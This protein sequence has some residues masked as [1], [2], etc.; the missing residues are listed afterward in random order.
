MVAFSIF[1]SWNISPQRRSSSTMWLL[2]IMSWFSSILQRWL[3]SLALVSLWTHE[4]KH[5]WCV[6]LHAVTIFIM[7]KIISSGQKP[8]QVGFWDLLTW[9]QG[10]LHNFAIW[11]KLILHRPGIGQLSKE[12]QLL[13]IKKRSFRVHFWALGLLTATLFLSLQQAELETEFLILFHITTL[14]IY[15]LY[16]TLYTQQSQNNSINPSTNNTIIE[17]WIKILLGNVP[18]WMV[19]SYQLNENL[20]LKFNC[21]TIYAKYFKQFQSPKK[22]PVFSILF[23]P[24]PMGNHLC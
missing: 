21:F 10:E 9:L 15:L 18:L 3:M 23:F 6:S 1:I 13:F 16:P 17:D 14:T 12:P 2:W 24:F 7:F 8:F 4:F 19:V 11:Y 22:V 20:F 5:I